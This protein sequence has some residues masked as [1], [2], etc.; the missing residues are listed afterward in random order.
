M[1]D[2]E[3]EFSEISRHVIHVKCVAVQG[4]NCR[5]FVDVDVLDSKILASLE[6]FVCSTVR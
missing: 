3:V 5:T 1:L 6:I 4:I 2:D